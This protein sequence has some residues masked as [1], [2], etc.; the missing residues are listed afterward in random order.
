LS[1]Q[2]LN[3]LHFNIKFVNNAK[4]AQNAHVFE[5]TVRGTFRRKVQSLNNM[6]MVIVRN[7]LT[8]NGFFALIKTDQDCQSKCSIYLLPATDKFS[9]LIKAGTP[10][11]EFFVQENVENKYYLLMHNKLNC[12]II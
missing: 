2:L 12:R 9:L 7:K 8:F 4:Y 6:N 1:D 10:P 11:S 3:S 5:T